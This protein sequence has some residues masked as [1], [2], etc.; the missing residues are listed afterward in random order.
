MKNIYTAFLLLLGGFAVFVFG[1]LYYT[2]FPTNQNQIYMVVLTLILLGCSVFIKKSP[3]LREYGPAVY[4]LFIAACATLFLSTGL[5]NIHYDGPNDLKDL[6]LDKFGQFSHVV[7]VILVLT[8]VA[9]EDLKSLY[10]TVGDLKKGLQFGI[11]SFSVFAILA[12]IIQIGAF[13]PSKWQVSNILY[14]LVFV[15]SNA[16]MEELWFRGLFLKKYASLVGRTGAILITA[17]IF[18][19]S[20]INATYDFPG[21]GYVFG[22]VVFALGYAGADSMLKSKSLIGPV[23]FHAGYDLMIILPVLNSM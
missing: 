8:L 17:V 2:V 11:L 7:P 6:A 21:G 19:A 22:A 5:L 18:G 9:R 23:L 3:T 4:A 16:I 15:F 10:I 20:H 14:L 12:F 1:N 13:E